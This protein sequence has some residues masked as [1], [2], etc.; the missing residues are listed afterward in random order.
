MKFVRKLLAGLLV[1][2]A[3]VLVIVALI[4]WGQDSIGANFLTDG[5]ALIGINMTLMSPM[6]LLA[7]A[8]VT[9]VIAY[10]MDKETASKIAEAVGSTVSDVIDQGIHVVDK[11]AKSI[12]SS[13]LVLL[14]IGGLGFYILSGD[15]NDY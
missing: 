3:L 8:G 2:L 11:A 13:P 7:L 9:L 15:K 12:L 6:A 14:A 4:Y 5:A 10:I 1:A